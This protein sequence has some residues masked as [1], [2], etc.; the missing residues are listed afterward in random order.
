M[1]LRIDASL[2][3][4]T[5]NRS[6]VNPEDANIRPAYEQRDPYLLWT[7]TIVIAW[8]SPSRRRSVITLTTSRPYR[9]FVEYGD[10]A[11]YHRRLPLLRDELMEHRTDREAHQKQRGR[12]S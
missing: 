11:G 2:R 7:R 5:R 10:A 12:H 8:S 4:S 3:Y 6:R 9:Q 1:I